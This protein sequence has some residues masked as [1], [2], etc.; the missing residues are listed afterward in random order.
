MRRQFA[1]L[2]AGITLGFARTSAQAQQPTEIKISY[3][4]AALLGAAVLRRG[5][6]GLVRRAWPEA[7]VQHV[8]RPACRRSPPRRRNRGMSAAPARCRPRSARSATTC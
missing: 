5:G 1:A 2:A 7:G 3:Q 8:S 6:K 4:P